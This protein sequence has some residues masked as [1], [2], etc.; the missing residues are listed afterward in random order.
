[1]ATVDT[2]AGRYGWIDRFGAVGAILFAVGLLVAFFTAADYENTAESVIAYAEDGGFELWW[3]QILALLMPLLVGPFVAT[4]AGRLLGV[5]ETLRIAALIGGTLFIA[6]VATALTLWSAPLLASDEL[7]TAGA[8]A[9]LA[10]DDAGW[11]LL[12]LG[13]VSA[14]VLILA[15]SLAA[16]G[17]RWLPVWAGWISLAL[18]LV[19]LAT[20]AAVGIFAW[21]AWL[22]AA[23]LVLLLRPRTALTD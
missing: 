8:E 6:F 9:Y 21:V 3:S 4:L 11:V 22:I 14:A 19:A 20:V 2:R 15:V 5:S 18:G 16:L 13:G 17:G 1:V 23:G 10:Y 12:G 7:T